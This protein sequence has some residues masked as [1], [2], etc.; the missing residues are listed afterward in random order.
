[1]D[2]IRKGIKY[3]TEKNYRIIVDSLRGRYSN[4][5]DEDYLKMVFPA[6]LGYPLNLD[7]PQTY[8]EKIQ[9]LKL[10]DRNPQYVNL[11][12]KYEVKKYVSEIVGKDYIIPTIGVW[13]RFDEINFDKLPMQFVLK[14]T[15]DSGGLV[16]C[17]NKEALDIK[18]AR[19][20]IERSLK[21]KYYLLG[22]EWPY[23]MVKPRI[24][25][26]EYIE[27]S[28]RE[29]LLDYKLFAFDGKV[30]ALFI[31][32]E[33]QAKG[34]ET[35]F[36]FFD[37]NFKHLDIWNG[38]PMAKTTPEKPINFELM[39]SLACK[40]S[41]GIPHVRVDFYEVNGK[42]LFGELTLYHWSGFVPFKPDKWDKIFGSWI[43][44]PSIRLS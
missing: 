6:H 25:A 18:K 36:D 8:N 19:N 35:K 22:R 33:R 24:I 23:K 11:V 29:D 40:L 16:I 38:H 34:S 42:V 31:A 30:K 3:I 4:M 5:P 20:K 27:D 1:M 7:N 32:S 9:W 13:D 28:K 43:N 21:Q 10:Y 39:K 2:Y 41:S 17:K 12:D 44:L 15:H 26:E 37:E 14:C